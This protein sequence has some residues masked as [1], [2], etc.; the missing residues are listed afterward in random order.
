M[1]DTVSVPTDALSA[2][3]VPLATTDPLASV[4]DPDGLDAVFGDALV[5]GLGEATHG[6]REFFRL[7]HRLI[8]YLVREHGLRVVA[9]EPNFPETLAIDEY[10][11]GEAFDALCHVAETSRA[12]PGSLVPTG[13][14]EPFRW[15]RP[16]SGQFRLSGC[17]G[18]KKCR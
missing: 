10:V 3:A 5:V 7:K 1:A 18:A 2:H 4:L 6:T 13:V 11:P 16:R 17:I 14:S 9:M 8:R 12:R 15:S